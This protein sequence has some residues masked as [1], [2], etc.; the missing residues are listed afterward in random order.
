MQGGEPTHQQSPW[1]FLSSSTNSRK[2]HQRR[3]INLYSRS[4][5]RLVIE[6]INHITGEFNLHSFSAKNGTEDLFLKKP[7][8]LTIKIPVRNVSLICIK[9]RICQ[10]R[11]N[12]AP[13]AQPKEPIN[14]TM[15]MGTLNMRLNPIL[16]RIG[17]KFP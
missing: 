3:I 4:H 11:P 2:D 6:Q 5:S 1:K 9:G 12:Y 17:G 15:R 10:S 14:V 7:F 8:Q 13:E 16:R